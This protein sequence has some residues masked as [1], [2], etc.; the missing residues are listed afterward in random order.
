MKFLVTLLIAA[1]L[2]GGALAVAMPASAGDG[3]AIAAGGG[4]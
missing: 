3:G 1:S 2:V 4:R